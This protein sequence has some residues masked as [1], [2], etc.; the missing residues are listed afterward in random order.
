MHKC[1]MLLRSFRSSNPDFYFR[2][3]NTYIRPT[4]EYGCEIFHPHSSSL[5][6]K[7]ESP[8]KFF[9]VKSFFD[10]IFPSSVIRF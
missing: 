10:V 7:L 8:L 5:A 3:F 6:K 9:P 4:L 1:R 2:L